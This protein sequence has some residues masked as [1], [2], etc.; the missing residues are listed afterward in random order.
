MLNEI[1]DQHSF[2]GFGVENV[3]RNYCMDPEANYEIG[4][5]WEVDAV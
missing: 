2:M 5:M 1:A 3:G 4:S